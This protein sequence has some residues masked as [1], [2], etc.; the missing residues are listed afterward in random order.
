MPK[1][2]TD[3]EKETRELQKK[4]KLKEYS[5]RAYLKKIEK[6]PDYYNK[7]SKKSYQLHREKRIEEATIRQDKK[8]EKQRELKSLIK[9]I[10]FNKLSETVN[11]KLFKKV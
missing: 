5:R 9:T 1:K 3:E 8:L 11:L 2:L 4:D 7:A 6:D 10:D